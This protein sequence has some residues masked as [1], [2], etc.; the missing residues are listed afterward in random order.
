MRQCLIALAVLTSACTSPYQ[1]DPLPAEPARTHGTPAR[2]EL[3][4]NAGVGAHAGTADLTVRVM[5]A[6]STPVQRVSVTLEATTGSLTPT[7]LVTDEN[8]RGAAL[9]SAPAG[10]VK[11]TAAIAN[12]LTSSTQVAIQG[13]PVTPN[14]SPN[15]PPTNPTPGL[16]VTLRANTVQLGSSTS[17][18][19]LVT[20][21]SSVQSVAWTFGDGATFSGVS[22]STAHIYGAIGSYTAG[23]T[24]TDSDGNRASASATA[25]VTAGPPP[26]PPP[27]PAMT[28]SLSAAPANVV[29][30]GTSTLTAT[31][32]LSN[33]ATAPT[34]YAW[35]C[36]GNG[37]V[38]TTTATNSNICPY[39][40]VGSF[41]PKVTAT[42]ANASATA[43]TTVT[44][45]LPTLTATLTSDAQTVPVGGMLNFTAAVTGLA[46]GETIRAYQWDLDA[47]AGFESTTTGNT[48]TSAPYTTAGL[49]VASVK[50]TT[51]TG[52][53]VTATTDYFVTS[54]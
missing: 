10:S 1:P 31:V 33:G 22:L 19:A 21:G 24:V 34:S 42:G 30:G 44:V 6:F 16:S 17:F 43:S 25:T 26:P 36:D 7:A 40:T 12:G 27:P 46:A 52:R 41:T 11:V 5:D 50:V 51:S 38:E 45:T 32:N 2:L 47:T 15:P 39:P 35:D 8:G 18:D 20:G 14:P 23:V 3:T 53:T 49:F 28:A 4:A 48:R 54:P 9:L 13:T 29:A 37:T